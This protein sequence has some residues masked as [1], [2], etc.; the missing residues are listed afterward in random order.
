MP[1]VT[2]L[3]RALELA[4]RAPSLHNSQPWRWIVD[5]TDDD[6]EVQLFADH[7]RI[8]R[9]TDR[10]GR[11]LV[12]SC[13]A[14]L[15]HLRVAMAAAGWQAGVERFP[16][17]NNPDHL[18]TVR[19]T[20]LPA[21]TPA[22]RERAE[23]ISARRTDRLPFDPPTDWS[24]VETVL[25]QNVFDDTVILTVLG[26]DARPRLAEASR[27]SESLRR[28]DA[29][30]HAELQWWTT[31]T[32][33]SQGLPPDALPSERERERVEIA[34]AFPARGDSDRR[35]EVAED[36]STIVVLAT[37]EDSVR[38]A[39]RC[40]EALSALLLEC[41][42]AGMATCPLTHMIEM[43]PSRDIVRELLDRPGLPQVLVRVGTTTGG[44]A[45]P[46]TPRRPLAEVVEF[47][48]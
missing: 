38:D 30:Y 11:E 5:R 22:H 3:E 43:Q 24:T 34:R 48:G 7:R 9:A 13:G 2:I 18:A 32:W 26:D 44:D 23:A 46:P 15:D 28:Y 41:T 27:L 45:P 37:P 1:S 29:S 40:G 35:P 4:C 17:P 10:S 6:T 19:F 12:I 20:A 21:V 36:R 14:A 47:R 33:V 8:G 39:L 16:N 31:P 25:R 42:M